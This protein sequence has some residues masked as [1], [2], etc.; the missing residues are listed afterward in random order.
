L[1]TIIVYGILMYN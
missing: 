1:T